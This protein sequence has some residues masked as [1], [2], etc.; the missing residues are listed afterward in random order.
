MLTHDNLWSNVAT[1]HRA[2]GFRPGDVLIHALPL[3][4]THGLFVALNLM[5][6]NG[7]RMIFLPR[8]EAETVIGLLPRATVLMGVPTFYTRLLASPGLTREAAAGMR[9]FVSGSA[10]LLAATHAEF[11]ARTGHRILERYGMT[12]TGMNASNPLDGERRAGHRRAGAARGRASGRATPRA[13][14]CRPG[15][16]GVLEVRG[17]NVFAG[18]WRMPEKTAE[19][20]RP[21]GWFVTGDLARIGADGYV[22]IVGRAQGPDHHR[23]AQRLSEG[24]RA[25]DRR[26][27]RAWSRA[28]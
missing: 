9:L 4:H 26:A 22:T 13:A 12:E 6:M 14:S 3:F 15:E 20:M 1:L 8:F 5:L 18:Y 21:G 2:W 28:R 27:A 17:P 10:P 24:G 7:G 19:E 11:E 25:G 16:T 23:R